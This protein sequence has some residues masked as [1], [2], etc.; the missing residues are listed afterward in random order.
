MDNINQ[1]I[2]TLGGKGTRLELVTKGVPKPLFLID[3][4]SVLERAINLLQNQGISK[5]IFFIN[6]LPELFDTASKKLI[7]K[8]NIK[9]KLIL[10]HR[11]SE[12][13]RAIEDVLHSK[14]KHQTELINGLL[15]IDLE[16]IIPEEKKARL[17][18]IK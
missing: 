8:Y 17:I 9:I 2:I 1:A 14:G 16:R 15:T 4:V 3:G 11:D 6:F 10:L 12:N 7:K 18:S 5:F 13:D